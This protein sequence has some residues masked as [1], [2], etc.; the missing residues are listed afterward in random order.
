MTMTPRAHTSNELAQACCRAQ[1]NPTIGIALRKPFH[2]GRR[3]YRIVCTWHSQK[4]RAHGWQSLEHKHVS[5]VQLLDD[6]SECPVV[7]VAARTP[8]RAGIR[9]YHSSNRNTGSVRTSFHPL[10]RSND[11]LDAV[12]AA[13]T[14][15]DSSTE[16]MGVGIQS[17][18]SLGG[19]HRALVRKRSLRVRA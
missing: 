9:Q 1:S 2:G 13:P 7:R 6:A 16:A 17:A 15:R 10:A 11:T 4:A 19:R 5:M 12:A 14:R 8:G 18:V 3:S